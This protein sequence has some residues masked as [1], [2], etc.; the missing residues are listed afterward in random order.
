M[1]ESNRPRLLDAARLYTEIAVFRRGPEDLPVSAVLLLL[2][3]VAYLLVT[4]GLGSVMPVTAGNRLDLLA[5]SAAF[6]VACYWVVLRLAGRPERFLQTLTAIFGF[7]LVIAP[8][9]VGFRALFQRYTA[10]DPLMLPVWF[11][12][13][14]LVLLIWTLAINGRI[15]RSATSWPLFSCVALVVLQE[16]LGVVV[17]LSVVPGEAAPAP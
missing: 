14:G 4:F 13:L 1:S 6:L 2:T 9:N 3:I 7:Q 16:L 12:M 17:I 15:L 5:L 10:A 8:I 11:M